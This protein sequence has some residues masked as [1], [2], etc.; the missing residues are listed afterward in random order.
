MRGRVHL[1]ATTDDRTRDALLRRATL[2]PALALGSGL[3]AALVGAGG[4]GIEA[5]AAT[6]Q[7]GQTVAVDGNVLGLA[8]G[9][10]LRQ[11]EDQ[12]ALQEHYSLDEQA[13]HD[14]WEYIQ[15]QKQ[16]TGTLPTDTSLTVERF[17][18]EL[19]DWR[20][21][22]LSPFG[23]QVHAPWALALEATLSQ[24]S[25]HEV[26]TLWSDDGIVLRF[27]DLGDEEAPQWPSFAIDPE[28]L[29]ELV[30]QQLSHSALFAG[31]FRENAG[32]SLLLPRKRP[33]QRSPLW[34]QRLKAQNLL[35]CA[36]QFPN[37][38]IVL[39]TYRSCL[40]DVFDLPALKQILTKIQTRQIR[41][42]EVESHDP[43]P[44]ARTLVYRYVANY[45]YQEDTP[46]AERKA[47]M[48]PAPRPE[49]A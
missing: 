6:M 26:Q 18:D 20:L 13:S 21:C 7:A 9:R 17:R 4:L 41:L 1:L 5:V 2:T 46:L 16:A 38:P 35:A 45:L 25:G 48:V 3:V 12:R 31:Q 28:D 14:L 30:L 29:E 32:R 27:S 44:F 11:L 22:L 33:G 37:F 15:E 39:E 49:P 19:G 40:Q 36:L 24:H 47:Q 23:S 34:A 8:I 10:F 43:S 42:I